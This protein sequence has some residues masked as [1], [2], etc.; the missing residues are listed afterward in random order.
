MKKKSTYHYNGFLLIELLIALGVFCFLVVIV[1][2][3]IMRITEQ[4]RA[5]IAT[6]KAMVLGKAVLNGVMSGAYSTSGSQDCP[7]I[8]GSIRWHVH[9]DKSLRVASFAAPSIK[10][11]VVEMV[12][13]G[14]RS[15]VW[16]TT[17]T[18]MTRG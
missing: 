11:C 18:D 3:Y 10:S 6:K 4:Q 7:D 5:I 2:L 8:G 12:R 17:H 16:R 15:I 9:N 13:P 14:E 1:S